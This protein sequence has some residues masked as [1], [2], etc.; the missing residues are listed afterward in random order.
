MMSCER[1]SPDAVSYQDAF[2]VIVNFVLFTVA[3]ICAPGDSDSCDSLSSA[4][5]RALL[6][7]ERVAAR[8]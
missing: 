8:T 2:S 5:I 4:A 6:S 3:Q 7:E 1:A